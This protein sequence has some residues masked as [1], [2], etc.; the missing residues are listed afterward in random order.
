M[1]R[2]RLIF[3]GLVLGLGFAN[4][5]LALDRGARPKPRP[6]E[7]L[8]YAVLEAP[9]SSK[10]RPRPRPVQQFPQ[11]DPGVAK[12][13]L[14]PE[15]SPRPKHR[16]KAMGPSKDGFLEAINN[17]LE[18]AGARPAK[19]T[20]EDAG[21]S[22]FAPVRS[23]RPRKRPA[24]LAQK[25]VA[26]SSKGSVCDVP[27]LK[28][29]RVPKVSGPLK[30]CGIEQPVRIS[31]VDGVGLSQEALIDCQTAKAL[32][33][34]VRK[35]LKP[36]VNGAGGGVKSIRLFAH[37]ACRS[38]N[39]KKGARISEHAKGHALDVGGVV[40]NN[41]VE[42]KVLEHWHS[43]KYGQ[44]LRR[45]H[46]SACGPFGT[47]LGPGADKYHQDHLHFDTARYRNGSYCR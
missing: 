2:L 8:V 39:S 12:T 3:F 38:R 10:V 30:G 42:L 37:Y 13:G 28:G 17:A 22:A 7:V 41:G 23:P 36:A 18:R 31:S 33:S 34:W 32:H 11:L 46:R 1:V 26:F 29:R 43:R 21:K 35:G 20:Q 14:S 45:M 15:R 47:V 4:H 24:D 5:V 27:G 19:A 9:E 40:L 16:P 6:A 44:I 25:T